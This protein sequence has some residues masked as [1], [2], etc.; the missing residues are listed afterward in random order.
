M[1]LSLPSSDWYTQYWEQL[2][3]CKLSPSSETSSSSLLGSSDSDYDPE[4][5]SIPVCSDKNE[6]HESIGYRQETKVQFV[7]DAVYAFAQALHSAWLDLC[8]GKKRVCKELKELDGGHFYKHYLLKVNF[9]GKLILL[10]HFCIPLHLWQV[11]L[12]CR[13]VPVNTHNIGKIY[14]VQLSKSN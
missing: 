13:S 6:I 7:V 4:N 10:D 5:T 14:F 8:R 11:S 1:I 12:V 2:F 9:T 3:S